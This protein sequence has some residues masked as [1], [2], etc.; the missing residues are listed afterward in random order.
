[1]DVGRLHWTDAVPAV[2]Q[3]LALLTM[4]AALGVVTWATAVNR[5]FSSVIRIQTDRGHEL[6]TA[7]PY[8]WVRHPAYAV[9]LFLVVAIGLALGSW[10][11]GLLGFL[12]VPAILRRT[13]REDRLLQEQLRGYGAYAREVRYRLLPGVW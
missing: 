11:A 9:A 5:F 4:A 6:V 3:W 2:V 1:M 13:A 10:L 12:L 7:G 8:R